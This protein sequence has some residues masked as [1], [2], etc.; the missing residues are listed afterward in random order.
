MTDFLDY[1]GNE[2][3]AQRFRQKIKSISSQLG[4]GPAA[5]QP[6]INA[7]LSRLNADLL[8]A[9]NR[10]EQQRLSTLSSSFNQLKDSAR[11]KAKRDLVSGALS[12]F[13]ILSTTPEQGS[14]GSF[15]H[16]ELRSLAFLGMAA[17]Y[18]ELEDDDNLIAE[19]LSNAIVADPKTAVQF[20][21]PSDAEHVLYI[22]RQ[23]MQ[24]PQFSVNGAI[25][26][27]NRNGLMWLRFALGQEWH[28]NQVHGILGRFDWKEAVEA[29][30]QFNAQGGFGGYTDWRMPTIEEL[31]T[32]IDMN[33]S[34]MRKTQHFINGQVFPNNYDMMW[35]SSPSSH[36]ETIV[37]LVDFTVGGAFFGNIEYGYGVR[38]V[39][40]P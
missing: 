33:I 29:T 24:Q 13:Y 7:Y 36:A 31:K 6:R 18:H 26:I 22:L 32:L 9:S 23:T 25:A 14:S 40:T 39:R 11:T 35:S 17:A 12:G 15:S 30:A 10:Q 27:D 28:H 20:L 3:A 34:R 21:D 38:L 37:W 1:F 5:T 4:I 16:K 2:I 8:L 19:K